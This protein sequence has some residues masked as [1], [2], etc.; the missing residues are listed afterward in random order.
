MG[1]V[2]SQYM[3]RSQLQILVQ[4]AK[5]DGVVSQDEIDL[6]RQVGK[7]NGLTEEDIATAFDETHEV[8]NLADLT[9]DEKYEY[10]YR[11]VQLMKIDGRLYKEEITYCAKMASKMGY[12]EDVLYHLITKIYSDPH[13]SADKDALKKKVQKYLIKN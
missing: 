10:M 6:I 8:G 11:V 4:L 9:D 7:A 2:T 5:I 13:V 12:N 3:S 1:T